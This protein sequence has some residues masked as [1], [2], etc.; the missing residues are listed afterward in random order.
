MNR[1]ESQ[2]KKVEQWLNSGKGIT[3]LEALQKWGVFRLSAIIFN[4]RNKGMDINT[5][6]LG[7]GNKKYAEYSLSEV[8][9]I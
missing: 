2:S 3:P 7:K 9:D 6:M 8:R 1:Y 4:L 5:K